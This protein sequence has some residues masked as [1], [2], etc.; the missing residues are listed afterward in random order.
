MTALPVNSRPKIRLARAASPKI[1]MAPAPSRSTRLA[2]LPGAVAA[3][4]S[5]DR[6]QAAAAAAQASEKMLEL[7]LPTQFVVRAVS[8][9][10]PAARALGDTAT[11]AWDWDT[12]S[13]VTASIPD[14]AVPYAKIQNVAA[15]SLLGS[16]AGGVVEEI[17][18]TGAGRALLDDGSASDQRA[19]LGLDQVD[20][21]SDADKPVSTAQAAAD[22]LRQL[23]S[24][25]GQ[26]NGYVPLDASAKVPAAFL[27]SYVD[28]TL[29]FASTAAFPAAGETGKIY[30]ALNTNNV[31]RWS[32]S[33][34][35]EIAASPGSTDEVTEGS[36]NLY[37]TAAR[38]RSTVLTGL[39]SVAAAVISAADTVIGALQKL[40][41]QI[42][43]HTT[44][45]ATHSANIAL[46][47]NAAS[48]VLT[49]TVEN[50]GAEVY[51]GDITPAALAANADNYNPPS[52]ATASRIRLSASTAIALTGIA[53]GADGRRLVLHNISAF[54]ITLKDD[55]TST[56]ANRFALNGDI[57][58]AQDQS[59]QIE[60]D[61]TTQ[62]W[63]AIGG[64]GGG[65]SGVADGD[66]GDVVVS[67]GA[68]AWTLKATAVA[69]L[70]TFTSLLKGLVPASAGGTSNFLRAD[71]TWAEPLMIG[72]GQSWQNVLGSR[73]ANTSYQNTTSRP[74]MWFC[75]TNSSV[76]GQFMQVSTN[77]AT[78]VNVAG[79]SDHSYAGSSIIIPPGHYY[80]V[81]PNV[82]I[83]VWTELR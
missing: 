25:K 70:N 9:T 59:I 52:L 32:G 14:S 71:G 28:D 75:R 4:H 73:A 30:V 51:S 1:R 72:A 12:G 8:P 41:A 48:P 20:N 38:V 74:I 66:K 15:G 61:G 42:T 16:I 55:G 68:T 54:A 40:Q 49:G 11:I 65:G 5:A 47:A 83:G 44:I 34:Y 23:L 77:N 79:V 80:R 67:L 13:A 63:R 24:E 2:I 29:E 22:G 64:I 18:L 78:W 45:I 19:T 76:G 21:T 57:V 6:S 62:R 39:T 56:A 26:A 7:A 3:Q 46:R 27:P 60:Y 81:T 10:L 43:D 33:T 50:Q 31:Y 69:S 58:L 17:A 53:A 82:A 35:V 37:F 36:V